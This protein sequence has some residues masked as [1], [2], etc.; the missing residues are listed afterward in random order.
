MDATAPVK[1]HLDRLVHEHEHL[2]RLVADLREQTQACLRGEVEAND[3]RS[4]VES[5]LRVAQ[6]ELFAH[7]ECEESG[8][9]PFLVEQLPDTRDTIEQLAAGH[10]RMCGLLVRMERMVADENDPRFVAEFESF[11]SLFARFDASYV[12]HARAEGALLRSLSGRLS[13]SQRV[14]VARLLA[15]L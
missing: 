2:N 12:Q 11:V 15:E 4:D 8:L 7:F 5:F 13:P 1:D 3:L 9:F 6:D 14:E 10:D